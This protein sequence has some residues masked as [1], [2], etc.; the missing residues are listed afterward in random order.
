MPRTIAKR[1]GDFA[2]QLV[3]RATQRS[4][5]ASLLVELEKRTCMHERLHCKL[6]AQTWKVATTVRRGRPAAPQAPTLALRAPTFALHARR[7][8]MGGR[9]D[10][11]SMSPCGFARPHACVASCRACDRM[12]T[13]RFASATDCVASTMSCVASTTR[14]HAPKGDN[15]H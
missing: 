11:P 1:F 8:D 9:H 14:K 12:P 7:T 5:L 4:E 10:C 15:L 2:T 13:P 3:E 6:A